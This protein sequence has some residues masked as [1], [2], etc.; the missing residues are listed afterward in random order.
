MCLYVWGNF[1]INTKSST[2][3]SGKYTH[4]IIA[5]N[6]FLLVVC[7]PMFAVFSI[8]TWQNVWGCASMWKWELFSWESEHKRAKTFK[9]A[10]CIGNHVTWPVPNARSIF[11]WDKIK[12]RLNCWKHTLSNQTPETIWFTDAPLHLFQ[13]K[14]S[15]GSYFRIFSIHCLSFKKYR[16]VNPIGVLGMS[17]NCIW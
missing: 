4:F 2:W 14:V 11:V 16:C 8:C 9:G 7:S 1:D 15:L 17:I 3:E 10:D 6:V 12:I 5:M 13:E